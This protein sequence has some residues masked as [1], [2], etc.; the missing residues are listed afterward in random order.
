M[1][2]SRL[3][4][5]GTVLLAAAGLSACEGNPYPSYTG[6]YALVSQEEQGQEAWPFEQQIP[7]FLEMTQDVFRR[8]GQGNRILLAVE[9][10]DVAVPGS[11]GVLDFSEGDTIAQALLERD[12]WDDTTSPLADGL[13]AGHV[14]HY[15][16]AAG[17][18]M[19]LSPSPA[20]LERLYP[21]H[22]PGGIMPAP[23][24]ARQQLPKPDPETW[25]AEGAPRLSILFHA[26][27]YDDQY[28]EHPCDRVVQGHHTLRLV[29][30]RIAAGEKVDLRFEATTQQEEALQSARTQSSLVPLMYPVPERTSDL[31]EI[32]GR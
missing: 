29:Y 16:L 4:A 28:P 9:S 2:V 30:E 3:S 32:F 26:G 7:E 12:R 11:L 27:K 21:Y 25:A 6:T 17:M 15:I 23:W 20:R 1:T 24:N 18:E 10:G 8:S 22:L 13:T 31:V 14:C 19:R 5:F